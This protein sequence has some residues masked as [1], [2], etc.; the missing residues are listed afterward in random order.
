MLKV[1]IADYQGVTVEGLKLYLEEEGIFEIVGTCHK[2]KD[3]I[4]LIRSK[5]PDLAIVGDSQHNNTINIQVIKELLEEG[6]P[7]HFII[8]SESI[9]VYIITKGLELGARGILSQRSGKDLLK[10]AFQIVAEGDFFVDSFFVENFCETVSSTI[11]GYAK[12]P[13]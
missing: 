13:P 10:E 5:K 2:T 11:R 1:I 4:K 9:D 12:E 3:L 7:T 8:F 6:I